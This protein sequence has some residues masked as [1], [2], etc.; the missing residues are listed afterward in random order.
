V[1]LTSRRNIDERKLGRPPSL[2]FASPFI[3]SAWPGRPGSR[4]NFMPAQDA[5]VEGQCLLSQATGA[6]SSFTKYVCHENE[7]A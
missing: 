6:E 3:L 1:V 5:Q 2:H 4:A 7:T